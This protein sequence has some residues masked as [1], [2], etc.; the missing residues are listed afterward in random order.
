MKPEDRQM[1][2]EDSAVTREL[3]LLLERARG[4]LVVASGRAEKDAPSGVF[5]SLRG[6]SARI[7]GALRHLSGAND[8]TERKVDAEDASSDE[9][10]TML[11]DARR[12]LGESADLAD[13][14][15]H[16]GAAD[17]VEE[18]GEATS[19]VI[20]ATRQLLR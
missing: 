1:T 17:I 10:G 13:R 12:I 15:E 19:L 11:A 9:L 7:E 16:S 14:A 18:V 4:I 5:R 20:R 2:G 6:A 8:E 3:R